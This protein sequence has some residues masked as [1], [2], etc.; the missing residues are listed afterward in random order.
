MKTNPVLPAPPLCMRVWECVCLLWLVN[1]LKFKL[2]LLSNV[3]KTVFFHAKR[4]QQ[5]FWQ[6][7]DTPLL[8]NLHSVWSS[9]CRLHLCSTTHHSQ[10]LYLYM[11]KLCAHLWDWIYSQFKNACF[12][13]AVPWPFSYSSLKLYHFRWPSHRQTLQHA[14]PHTQN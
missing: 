2:V 11:P 8:P 13:L 1:V 4:N 12:Y 14:I 3:C 10:L 6:T 9:R 5:L 7:V